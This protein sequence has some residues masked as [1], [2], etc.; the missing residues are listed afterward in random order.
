M[1]KETTKYGTNHTGRDLLFMLGG[2][3]IGAVVGLITAPQSG[4]RTRRQIRRRVEDIKDQA[5]DLREEVTGRVEDLRK[6]AARQINVGK[7]YFE[8]KKDGFFTSLFNLKDPLSSLR[9]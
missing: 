9:R 2:V 3:A 8:G 5:V 6:S 1:W 7:E 4:E